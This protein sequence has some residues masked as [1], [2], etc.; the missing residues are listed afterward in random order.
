MQSNEDAGGIHAQFER[1]L[2]GSSYIILH[3]CRHELLASKENLIHTLY[4]AGRR[5]RTRVIVEAFRHY[6]LPN[7]VFN[8][9]LNRTLRGVETNS[10]PEDG[11]GASTLHSGNF[12]H[13]GDGKLP[14]YVSGKNRNGKGEGNEEKKTSEEETNE[15]D[16][17]EKKSVNSV[18]KAVTKTVAYVTDVEGNLDY[19]DQYLDLS[20]VIVR[21]TPADGQARALLTLVDNSE[22]VYGG[23][24]CDRGVGDIRFILEM[25]SLKEAYP[26]RVHFI[27]GN[28][29]LN[30]LRFAFETT[31]A[32][33][34][35]PPKCYWLKGPD[36]GPYDFK[37]DKIEPEGTPDKLSDRV[38]WMLK[39][40]MGSP[41]CFEFRKEELSVLDTLTE[42]EHVAQSFVD[43]VRADGKSF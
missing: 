42:D 28:R 36:K 41:D 38:K 20:D 5:L 15:I 2:I 19:W 35:E 33:L 11:G 13:Q 12:E 27:L 18:E 9:Q 22:V 14:L 23:D 1:L 34:S 26:D 25:L 24:L 43:S 31:E 16:N 17:K 29:D 40:T 30:K 4:S 10:Q 21:Q 37:A 39:K 8:M 7:K 3:L 32:Q 6:F